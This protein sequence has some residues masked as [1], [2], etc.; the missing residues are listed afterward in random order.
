MNKKGNE[1]PNHM[2][3]RI[4]LNKL[5]SALTLNRNFKLEIYIS[6]L[7]GMHWH[8]YIWSVEKCRLMRTLSLSMIE[9]DIKVVT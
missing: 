9:D 4:M 1:I 3:L 5:Y 2:Y 8:I 6:Y 7:K